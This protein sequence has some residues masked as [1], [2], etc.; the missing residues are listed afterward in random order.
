MRQLSLIIV[1]AV[2]VKKVYVLSNPLLAKQRLYS[3]RAESCADPE[4]F[5][6]G[7]PS[8]TTLFYEVREDLNGTIRVPASA[9]H[10]NGVSLAERRGPKCEC[11]LGKFVIFLWILTSIAEKPYIFV[12]FQG[13]GGS[14]QPAPPPLS[15]SAHAPSL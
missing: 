3:G 10:L 15:G 7:D 5:F 9:R 12:I 13:G 8:L 1:F 11:W 6:I 2:R 14:G 4:S